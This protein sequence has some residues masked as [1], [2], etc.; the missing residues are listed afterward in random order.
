[1]VDEY[2]K[3]LLGMAPNRANSINLDILELPCQDMP[4]LD[5]AFNEEEVKKIVKSMPMDKLRDRMGSPP[6]FK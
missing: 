2:Y 4:G 5:I 6:A 3:E 1:M